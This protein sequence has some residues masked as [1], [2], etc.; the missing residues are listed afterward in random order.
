MKLMM[1]ALLFCFMETNVVGQAQNETDRQYHSR[2]INWTIEIPDGWTVVTKEKEQ[3]N[4]QKGKKALEKA[5]DVNIDTTGLKTLVRFQ[6][7]KFN[8]FASKTLP[9]KE[10]YPGAYEEGLVQQY[11]A[12][13]NAFKNGGIKADT[14]SGTETIQGMKFYTLYAIL[15]SSKGDA[16]LHQVIYNK[17]YKG[18]AWGVVISYNSTRYKEKM[19]NAFKNSKFN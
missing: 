14:S 5:N 2:E 12:M 4:D 19:L 8:V 7:D 18:Y 9:M 16:I 10:D 15:Y 11:A 6:K 3:E 1:L 13:F 17:F